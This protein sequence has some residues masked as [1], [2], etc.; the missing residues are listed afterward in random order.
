MAS[1]TS[2]LIYKN[3][4]AKFFVIDRDQSDRESLISERVE[5]IDRGVQFVLENIPN[6]NLSKK[7]QDIVI[8]KVGSME[9]T[10]FKKWRESKAKSREHFERKFEEWIH[11]TLPLPQSIMSESSRMKGSTQQ[12]KKFGEL[13]ERQKERRVKELDCLDLDQLLLAATKAAK[14]SKR[15]DLAYVLKLLYKDE[16]CAGE[17]RGLLKDR[18]K[19]ER[20][21]QN[22]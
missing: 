9:T 18:N 22:N 6:T 15:T 2:E 16:R 3:I 7:L 8:N 20:V 14:I 12:K 4:I 1:T 5:R 19:K 10:F 13:S 21:K 17:I 11:L